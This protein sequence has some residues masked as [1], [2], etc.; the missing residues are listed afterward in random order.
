MIV[1]VS[2]WLLFMLT[3]IVA[4]TGITAFVVTAVTTRNEAKEEKF[5]GRVENIERIFVNSADNI[6]LAYQDG[7]TSKLIEFVSVRKITFKQDLSASD[8]PWA[9]YYGCTTAWGSK[10]FDYLEIHIHG[11]YEL[12]G[13]LQAIPEK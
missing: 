4:A 2:K 1:K 7:K 13:R 5:R 9:K 12:D 3:M 6:T 10:R 8:K 11:T